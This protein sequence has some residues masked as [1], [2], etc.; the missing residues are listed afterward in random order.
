MD[1]IKLAENKLQELINQYN[2]N[3][4][5]TIDAVKDWIWR[6]EGDDAFNGFNEKIL[7]HFKDVRDIDE[8]NRILQIFN[9]AWNYFPHKCL[10]GKS[11]MQTTTESRNK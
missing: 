5:L 10:N 6:E 9:E 7:D 2:L 1:N 11:P 8:F 4:I 3:E